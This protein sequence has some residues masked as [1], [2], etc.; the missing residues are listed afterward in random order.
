MELEQRQV[1]QTEG[2]VLRCAQTGRLDM[3]QWPVG[4]VARVQRTGCVNNTHHHIP[5]EAVGVAW[6]GGVGVHIVLTKWMGVLLE[7]H[8]CMCCGLN[9]FYTG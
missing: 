4:R 3:E 9:A 8:A 6:W 1:G 2:L 7:M 5:Q